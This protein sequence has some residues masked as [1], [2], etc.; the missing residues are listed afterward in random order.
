MGRGRIPVQDLAELESTNQN[1]ASVK[2]K[3]EADF[4]Q[5]IEAAQRTS[6]GLQTEIDTLLE[7]AGALEHRL[8]TTQQERDDSLT[9]AS[10]LEQEVKRLGVDAGMVTE[11]A[12]KARDRA[13]EE[14]DAVR[15]ELG[16]LKERYG[17]MEED[18]GVA[19]KDRD[20]MEERTSE[21]EAEGRV[22]RLEVDS[23]KEK[24][25]KMENERDEALKAKVCREAAL[26][27]GFSIGGGSFVFRYIPGVRM[28]VNRII[29]LMLWSFSD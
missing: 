29:T 8:L 5:E 11:E 13:L 22:L 4:K 20:S 2:A 15:A 10:E 25:A 14:A 6:I 23:E 3:I 7:S 12:T 24:L 16:A 27:I 19:R 21:V 9:R 1:L 26:F 17:V 18:L 28:T